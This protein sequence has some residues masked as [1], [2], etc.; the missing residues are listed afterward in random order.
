MCVYVVRVSMLAETHNNMHCKT[1]KSST[2][3]GDE[4]IKKD[5]YINRHPKTLH[6]QTKI[7]PRMES[8]YTNCCS[9]GMLKIHIA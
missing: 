8:K 5:H 6:A 7:Y 1:M 4:D 9:F 2:I 3:A